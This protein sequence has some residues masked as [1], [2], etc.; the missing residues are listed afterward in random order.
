M[1]TLWARMVAETRLWDA[2]V[3]STGVICSNGKPNYCAMST[4]SKLQATPESIKTLIGVES[5][6]LVKCIGWPILYPG[7]K[8]NSNMWQGGSMGVSS[9]RMQSWNSVGSSKVSTSSNTIMGVLHLCPGK[10]GSVQWKHSFFRI[11]SWTSAGVR[12]LKGALELWG[13]GVGVLPGK[14]EVGKGGV[15]KRVRIRVGEGS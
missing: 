13:Y 1:V 8:N 15:K 4:R 14:V 9:S 2:V 10:W 12:R 7:I 6:D 5:I 11:F 3:N